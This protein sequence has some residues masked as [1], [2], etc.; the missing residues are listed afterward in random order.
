M[1]RRDGQ[2]ALEQEL[3]ASRIRLLAGEGPPALLRALQS[4]FPDLSQNLYIISWVPEQC[5]DIYDVLVDAT[6]VV[7]V[8]APR[9][10]I[11]QRLLVEEM[12]LERYEEKHPLRRA[13]RRRLDT[14]V[15]LALQRQP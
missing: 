7:H 14:A 8:E 3:E 10:G 11:S 1:G 5:E 13:G 2:T 15:R 6:M 12:P 9:P 4:H